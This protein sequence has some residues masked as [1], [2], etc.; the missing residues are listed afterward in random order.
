MFTLLSARLKLFICD[1][2]ETIFSE[3]PSRSF[4]KESLSE[5]MLSL[6]VLRI[7]SCLS[8]FSHNWIALFRSAVISTLLWAS[9]S[10]LVLIS[11]I[12]CDVVLWLCSSVLWSCWSLESSSE[13]LF[14]SD[15]TV[16]HSLI[17]YYVPPHYIGLTWVAGPYICFHSLGLIG[18]GEWR[19]AWYNSLP[20]RM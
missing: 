9:S 12:F 4:N 8:C 13:A 6:P 19:R 10:H 1:S 2:S 17:N 20:R 16:S 11:L 15:F 14:L 18:G 3:R 7:S 5:A